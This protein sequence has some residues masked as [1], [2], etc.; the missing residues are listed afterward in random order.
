VF[1]VY[2]AAA[3]GFVSEEDR[4]VAS[5]DEKDKQ[6]DAGESD[7]EESDREQTARADGEAA[8]SDRDADEENEAATRAP[9]NRAERRQLAKQL[10]RGQ[11]TEDGVVKEKDRN[12]A[13]IRPK[14]P[15]LTVTGRSTANVDEV[16]PWV[17]RFGDWLSTHRAQ[18]FGGIA[19]MILLG[20]GIAYGIDKRASTRAAD[21]YKI[22]NVAEI[23]VAEV[24]GPDAPPDRPGMPPR[25]IQPY[26]DYTARARAALSAAEQASQASA[27]P[28]AASIA[29]F[30]R[31]L[32]LYDLGRYAE[33]KT[34]L[35]G[36]IGSDLAG[37]E[38]RALEVLGFSLEALND[39]PGALRRF[40]EL[41]RIEG[42]D[43]RNLG[44][45]HQ[46]RVLRRQNQNDRAK[47]LLRRL[48]ERAD[49]SRPDDSSPSIA[50]AVLEQ[51]RALLH[52]MAPED[53]LGRIEAAPTDI[54]SIIRRIQQQTGGHVQIRTQGQGEEQ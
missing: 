14:V 6:H 27:N 2:S 7:E 32:A 16:P 5:D 23:F 13:V 31:G 49:R 43:W 18:A 36:V 45:Y 47:D 11:V 37:L 41:A 8:S 39:L 44:A 54:E 22:V 26:P 38:P 25:R 33:A 19:V 48:I 3:F 21:A 51:A 15:P 53:P 20:V 42:D 9:R 12:K 1:G 24:R 29:R 10:K 28:V 40:E 30:Q 35:E 46:A 17:K 50:R 34:A 4:A 52:E